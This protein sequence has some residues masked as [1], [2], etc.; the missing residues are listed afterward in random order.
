MA[1][2]HSTSRQTLT[3][4]YGI[5]LRARTSSRALIPA[6]TPSS[7]TFLSTSS[8]WSYTCPRSLQKESISIAS[9]RSLPVCATGGRRLHSTNA[10]VAERE[11]ETE[12]EIEQGYDGEQVMS[13]EQDVVEPIFQR[14]SASAT[15]QLSEMVPK[16]DRA[17]ESPAVRNARKLID[18]LHRQGTTRRPHV[19][20]HELEIIFAAL[21]EESLALPQPSLQELASSGTA[22]IAAEASDSAL[23]AALSVLDCLQHFRSQ[24]SSTIYDLLIRQCMLHG[25]PDKAAMV[26][27]GLIEEWILEGRLA[28]GGDLEEFAEG[29]LPADQIVANMNAVREQRKEGLSEVD[30]LSTTIDTPSAAETLGTRESKRRAASI[31]SR[32]NGWFEGIRSWRLPGEVIAP[33]DRIRLW[34]PKKL[35]LKEKMKNFPMPMPMSPPRTIPTPTLNLLTVILDGLN[36]ERELVQQELWGKREYVAKRPIEFERCSRALAYLA[37]TIL[38]RT[39]PITA[40]ARLMKAFRSLPSSPPVYPE[41]LKD[42][43][44]TTLDKEVYSAHIQCQQA[45]YSLI[46]APPALRW[47]QA[48][49]G[50]LYRLQPMDIIAANSLLAWG[51][52]VLHKPF[53]IDKLFSYFKESFGLSQLTEATRNVL[54][55]F[56]RRARDRQNR[57]K[58]LSETD[59]P[60]KDRLNAPP[61]VST[62][63]WKV[64]FQRH[65][66]QPATEGESATVQM[67][68]AAE[69]VDPFIYES[70]P[71]IRNQ[72]DLHRM[73]AYIQHLT[74]TTQ[75]EKLSKFIYTLV[76]YLDTVAYPEL[77][78]DSTSPAIMQELKR[79]Q[80]LA[81]DALLLPPRIY[82]LIL[83]ALQQAGKTGLAE[84]VFHIA[85]RS[86]QLSIQAATRSA[87]RSPSSSPG[88]STVQSGSRN[89]PWFLPEHAYTSMIVM[90]NDEQRKG[91]TD[92]ARA[93][94]T[95]DSSSPPRQKRVI[96]GWGMERGV[97]RNTDYAAVARTMS[98]RIYVQALSA[99]YHT[100][101]DYEYPPAT[102]DWI[103]SVYSDYLDPPVL[104]D[105]LFHAYS[106]G[107]FRHRPRTEDDLKRS[108]DRKL[109]DVVADLEDVMR[110][111]KVWRVRFPWVV[112]QKYEWLKGE[113]QARL[114]QREEKR[115]DPQGKRVL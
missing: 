24:R 71:Y 54:L 31:A 62:E 72:A 25:Y 14:A 58:R 93:G 86:S 73:T 78:A 28:E 111:M 3:R 105:K 41:N 11:Q 100:R 16:A 33:L 50:S 8:G 12:N 115:A 42:D 97:N 103:R 106:L 112:K 85:H 57:E 90:Y 114:R 36:F 15:D 89:P 20:V 39:L 29:G 47:R 48:S 56:G 21:M 59:I 5:G 32:M 38:S 104:D 99:A 26:Y 67:L 108:S 84:R 81:R 69:A 10:A 101:Q 4:S 113:R 49:R 51:L 110:E 80:S 60:G 55:R 94:Q 53:F 66:V 13:G 9:I 63:Q 1:A 109:D 6:P 44:M 45:L 52:Q 88:G 64:Y 76:P 98:Y 61:N 91:N 77:A 74:K 68:A 82:V 75:W 70:A 7:A 23:Q 19:S 27:V 17:R 18:N 30:Q 37:N 87:S 107:L 96:K 95:M 79:R 46:M 2:I 92:H 102:P 83:G 34:H 35:A 40:L 22:T 43:G 65:L